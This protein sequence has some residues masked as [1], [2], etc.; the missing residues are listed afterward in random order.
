MNTNIW[1]I[2][3]PFEENMTEDMAS[4]MGQICEIIYRILVGLGYLIIFEFKYK[5]KK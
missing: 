1:Y 4:A 3:L 5:I 2:I